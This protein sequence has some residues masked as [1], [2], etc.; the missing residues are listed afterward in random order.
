MESLTYTRNI[1]SVI[2]WV[3]LNWP[4]KSNNLMLFMMWLFMLG[5]LWGR[6][7][8]HAY[9]AIKLEDYFLILKV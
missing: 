3:F 8:N 1:L 9:A 7:K 6:G 5:V 2:K 4:L